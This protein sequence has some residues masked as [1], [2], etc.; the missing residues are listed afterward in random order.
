LWKLWWKSRIVGKMFKIIHSLICFLQWLAW[1]AA[2]GTLS[3]LHRSFKLGGPTNL[4]KNYQFSTTWILIAIFEIKIYFPLGPPCFNF[5]AFL[6]KIHTTQFRRIVEN[7][8]CPHS[9][10]QQMCSRFYANFITLCRY[11]IGEISQDSHS[12]WRPSSCDRI[13]IPPRF[14]DEVVC[15]LKVSFPKKVSMVTYVLVHEDTSCEEVMRSFRISLV[16]PF[17]MF[18]WEN[19]K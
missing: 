16:K 9:R 7:S 6:F 5:P 3:V 13:D 1:R 4:K 11:Q 10:M 8:N 19:L 2:E 12:L 17:P 15:M 14:S 18:L